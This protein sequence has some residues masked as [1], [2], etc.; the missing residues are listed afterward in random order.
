MTSVPLCFLGSHRQNFFQIGGAARSL[1]WPSAQWQRQLLSFPLS[2]PCPCPTLCPDLLVPSGCPP[3]SPLVCYSMGPGGSSQP[4]RIGGHPPGAVA[5]KPRVSE[6]VTDMGRG[7]FNFLL[8][9]QGQ[10]GG[11]VKGQSAF[12]P[13]FLNCFTCCSI[14]VLVLFLFLIF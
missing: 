9:L 5:S 8:K 11:L 3:E 7:A 4:G 1:T 6:L 10:P 14:C 12:I 13:R 2:G